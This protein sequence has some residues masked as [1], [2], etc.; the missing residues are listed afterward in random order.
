MVH[1]ERINTILRIHINE[2][3]FIIN[4]HG[5]PVIADELRHSILRNAPLSAGDSGAKKVFS[6]HVLREHQLR[7]AA[8]RFPIHRPC[9]GGVFQ[10]A[11]GGEPRAQRCILRGGGNRHPLC[12]DEGIPGQPQLR[13]AGNQRPAC[14]QPDD[15][16]GAALAMLRLVPGVQRLHGVPIVEEL[17]AVVRRGG[18]R[19]VVNGHGDVDDAGF[20]NHID[21]QRGVVDRAPVAQNTAFLQRGVADRAVV[22]HPDIVARPVASQR[23][24]GNGHALSNQDVRIIKVVEEERRGGRVIVSREGQGAATPLPFFVAGDGEGGGVLI[25]E[26]GYVV[27]QVH[28]AVDGLFPFSLHVVRGQGIGRPRAGRRHVLH[29]TLAPCVAVDCQAVLVGIGLNRLHVEGQLIAHS[30]LTTRPAAA[31]R[32]GQLRAGQDIDAIVRALHGF[33]A[34]VRRLAEDIGAAQ[35][36]GDLFRANGD[37]ARN[38]QAAAGSDVRRNVSHRPAER[39]RFKVLRVDGQGFARLHRRAAA[40]IRG[41]L[42]PAILDGDGRNQHGREL[43]VLVRQTEHSVRGNSAAVQRP[44]LVLILFALA[45]QQFNQV[46]IVI[47]VIHR[48]GFPVDGDGE[49]DGAVVFK[50]DRLNRDLCACVCVFDRARNGKCI[51]C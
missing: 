21:G 46:R 49:S 48:S 20:V 14:V 43:R 17:G 35:R 37:Y 28:R 32:D 40:G 16:R 45:V 33:P 3:V 15:V 30:I 44:V 38:L 2:F 42:R 11:A 13:I 6:A 34:A 27:F 8:D 5:Y 51:A 39:N 47:R 24:A 10:T 36:G 12:A 4:T 26:S 18:V 29:G 1:E 9:V 25:Y 19:L 41:E 7:P 22:V 23:H 31:Q 50:F